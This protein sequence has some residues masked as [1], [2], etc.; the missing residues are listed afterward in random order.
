MNFENS[1]F[2]AY[3]CEIPEK[4]FHRVVKVKLVICSAAEESKAKYVMDK[5]REPGKEI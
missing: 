1:T 5:P 3:R 4:Q 2:V